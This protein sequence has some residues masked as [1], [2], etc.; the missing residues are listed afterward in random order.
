MIKFVERWIATFASSAMKI[1]KIKVSQHGAP[2][3]IEFAAIR[4]LK[5][6]AGY[7]KKW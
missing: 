3:S 2:L 1:W 5:Q 7:A 4:R 6:I